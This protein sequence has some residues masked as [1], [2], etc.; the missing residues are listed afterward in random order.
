MLFSKF[1]QKSYVLIQRDTFDI[2]R[3]VSHNLLEKSAL[4]WQRYVIQA[5]Y[6]SIE[7]VHQF[8]WENVWYTYNGPDVCWEIA[9]V[10]IKII[11]TSTLKHT[12][13]KVPNILALIEVETISGQRLQHQWT[14][15]STCS[16]IY[17]VDRCLVP[18]W[19]NP[20]ANIRKKVL[21]IVSIIILQYHYYGVTVS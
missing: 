13:M 12:L 10:V 17:I 6:H 18:K 2:L 16:S 11:I 14:D 7:R 19:F 9:G 3:K 20:W 8:F 1:H 5:C 15:Y 4:G 21:I